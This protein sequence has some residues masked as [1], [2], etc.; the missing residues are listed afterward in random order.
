M[1][2]PTP[3]GSDSKKTYLDDPTEAFSPLREP[4]GG[5]AGSDPDPDATEILAPTA[6][7]SAS[8]ASQSTEHHQGDGIGSK[9]FFIGSALLAGGVIVAAATFL[10]PLND[11][12]EQPVNG[13]SSP[14]EVATAPA[15]ASPESDTST[16]TP[17]FNTKSPTVTERSEETE[18]AVIPPG[19]VQYA[20]TEQSFQTQT[21]Y[22]EAP[23]P[24]ETGAVIESP[25]TVEETAPAPI[26]P[27]PSE[28]IAPTDSSPTQEPD[29]P[30]ET[31][32]PSADAVGDD[33]AAPATDPTNEAPPAP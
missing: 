12:A 13:S 10:L 6:V 28:S 8:E 20:P 18:G 31:V 29:S 21:T 4:V 32:V 15:E 17:S 5:S 22:E 33:A 30:A 23:A 19:T 24:T 11:S 16:P 1:D 25:L 7:A 9:V 27:V 2:A 14:T 3:Q 26:D